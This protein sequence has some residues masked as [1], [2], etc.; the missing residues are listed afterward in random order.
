MRAA[1]G[2]RGEQSRQLFAE[3]ALTPAHCDDDEYWEA[4][5][6]IF[7][8]IPTASCIAFDNFATCSEGLSKVIADKETGVVTDLSRIEE[9]DLLQTLAALGFEIPAEVLKVAIARR[10]ED[11]SGTM[12]YRE[13]VA[14]LAAL[15]RAS[16]FLGVSEDAA[17]VLADAQM[18]DRKLKDRAI[19][20]ARREEKR[21]AEDA[22]KKKIQD[23]KRQAE[24]AE[25]KKIQDA[26]NEQKAKMNAHLARLKHTKSQLTA[27]FPTRAEAVSLM[28]DNIEATF[29]EY[30]TD[31]SGTI[32]TTSE[33]E[34]VVGGLGIDTTPE[35][36][37]EIV[38]SIDADGSGTIDL[39]EFRDLLK[40][41]KKDILREGPVKVV[42]TGERVARK[43]DHDH[44]ANKVIVKL[45]QSNPSDVIRRF[46]LKHTKAGQHY[47]VRIA[48]EEKLHMRAERLRRQGE[49]AETDVK[50]A[51]ETKL[52]E[53]E[54]RRGR[55]AK[56]QAK[57]EAGGPPDERNRHKAQR[58]LPSR[59][60]FFSSSVFHII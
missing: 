17:L 52:V 39:D 56:L 49:N 46:V 8:F 42:T 60:G 55:A 6:S 54:K 26:K 36:L 59:P 15:Q 45:R 25:K 43:L 35:R 50:I 24:D 33:L 30:D 37:Q 27:G 48:V 11:E 51:A 57:K 3:W 47:R 41:L 22:V 40:V 7:G 31:R 2:G 9:E 28:I 20:A 10:D 18:V 13:F 38:A 32:G 34:G 53:K 1:G 14:L 5:T 29:N 12:G 58:S 21:Q 16:A 4:L 19:A 23:A 44:N